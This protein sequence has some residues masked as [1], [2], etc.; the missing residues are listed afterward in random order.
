MGGSSPWKIACADIANIF[1][2]KRAHRA[3]LQLSFSSPERS[4][5]ENFRRAPLPLQIATKFPENWQFVD[6]VR[7]EGLI[8]MEHGGAKSY[9]DALSDYESATKEA[10]ALARRKGSTA[11]IS[12]HTPRDLDLERELEA[13]AIR[14]V[15]LR[16]HLS[17]MA[18]LT[19]GQQMFQ[20][21]AELITEEVGKGVPAGGELM[22][23]VAK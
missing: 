12:Q 19:T 7:A 10:I 20:Q 18:V 14:A 6:S 3:E 11:S 22:K 8:Q 21:P 13:H 17:L 23:E 2:D 9:L 4:P 1:A 15:M 16:W 5:A